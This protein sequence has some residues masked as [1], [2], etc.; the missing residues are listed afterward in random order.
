MKK[1]FCFFL[2]CIY[3]AVTA[4]SVGE[5]K[6]TVGNAT[7]PLEKAGISLLRTSFSAIA[8][9]AGTFEIKNIPAGK[10]QLL[11]S[12]VGYENFQQQIEIKAGRAT[13]VIAE[14]IPL[15]ARLKEIVV[16][17]TMKEVKKIESITPVEVYAQKYFQRNTSSNLFDAL[18]NINGFFSDIDNGVSNTTD[19][20]ING[21]EGNYTM[22]LIDGVPA[23]NGLAGLYALNAL[24]LSIIDKIEVLKGASS[25]LYGSDAIAGIINIK[26][27]S[28]AQAP[29]FSSNVCLNSMLGVN[30][31]F[32]VAFK[33]KKASSFIAVSGESANYRW[34]INGDNFTDVPLTNR[35]N[36]FNKWSFVRRENRVANIY[37]RYLFED[38]IGGEMKPVSELRNSRQYYSEAVRT[39]QWQAGLQY[40][41][42]VSEKVLLQLDYSEHRQQA[43]FGLNLFDGIQRNVFSQL[44]W[45][46][47]IDSVNELLMGACYRLNNY[48]DNTGLS[49]DSITGRGKFLHVVGLFIE[50]ELVLSKNH[51]LLLGARFEYN[52]QSGPVFTPRVNYKWHS[53]DESNIIRVGLGTGYR[54]PNLLNEGF[55][56]LNGS[57]TIVVEEKL[58]A[59][60]ALN[61]N[62]GYTRIQNLSSGIL[63]MEAGVFYT[64]FFNFI[65]PDY[66]QDGLIV[67]QNNKLGAMASGF[68]MNADFSFH[69][70][71]KIGVGFTY[72]NVFERERNEEGEIEKETPT[73]VPPF[74]ANFFLSYTFPAPQLSIDWTGNVV[75]PMLLATVTDD[76]RPTHSPWFTIQNIQLT[77][78][79]NNGIEIYAGLKNFFN[80]VQKEP[81]LRPFDPF[82]KNV[83]VG[84]PANYRFDTSYGFTSTEGIKGFIGFR[85]NL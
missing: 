55:A 36:F 16:T 6:G 45:S 47:K 40:Q 77:K 25:T 72:T 20:Q 12:Y 67:Y 37:A 78:K 60:L 31:D 79:F 38:R 2:S 15:N 62:A 63:N 61:A 50:D 9:S 52:N 17:G 64:Y 81:I 8:D 1:F 22:V 57:R 33:M 59:E 5:L 24:P 83:M 80:F 75:S 19:V 71:L 34:D 13:E 85:Y 82:N 66:S 27:K 58:N 43:N 21:L 69:Y 7:I 35:V 23:M 70:P 46:K 26:T 42:P 54:V 32:S 76:F 53:N 41:L 44:T 68:S 3:V 39:H 49:E 56:A 51:Q 4:Q 74:V 84:N 14:I 18:K 73:H 65:N 48:V 30:A 10:Y 28:P 11:I 29:R